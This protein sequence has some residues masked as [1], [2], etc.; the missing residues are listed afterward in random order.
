MP[1]KGLAF[2]VGGRDGSDVRSLAGGVV[3]GVPHVF[4]GD[5]RG[6][7]FRGGT[8]P[9]DVDVRRRPKAHRGAISVLAL[10]ETPRGAVLASGDD[11]WVRLWD[12]DLEP[13]AEID[14]GRSVTALVWLGD[15]LVIATDRGVLC[16]TVRC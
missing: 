5:A 12:P 8:S 16:V 2:W 9:E 4:G 10:R 1:G 14:A 3:V 7:L 15:D 13:L 11:G 6:V